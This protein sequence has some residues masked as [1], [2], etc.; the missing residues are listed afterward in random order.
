MTCRMRMRVDFVVWAPRTDWAV[1]YFTAH[2]LGYT[3]YS[4]PVLSLLLDTRFADRENI[5]SRYFVYY[6]V[7]ALT[8]I[9]G[10]SYCALSHSSYFTS[11]ESRNLFIIHLLLY[12]ISSLSI[13]DLSS[14]FG[15]IFMHLL[16]LPVRS[17]SWLGAPCS[18]QISSFNFRLFLSELSSRN[19]YR[20]R[21]GYWKNSIW[22]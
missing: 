5:H 9:P 22:A 8:R 20:T 11:R 6:P 21:N 19:C 3:T 17:C 2:I 12:L 15:L 16:F 14:P 13:G 1:D 4:F 10:V 7:S 18:Y